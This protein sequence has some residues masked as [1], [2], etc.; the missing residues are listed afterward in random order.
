MA[1]VRRAVGKRRTVIKHEF[2][3]A[4]AIADGFFKSLV[5]V[6]KSEDFFFDFD[7]VGFGLDL[8]IMCSHL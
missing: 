5:F 3:G 2:G 4:V 7:K 1:I 6:P 8:G